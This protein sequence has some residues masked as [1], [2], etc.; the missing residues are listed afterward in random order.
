MTA[1]TM[2]Y[3]ISAEC[4]Q[5]PVSPVF[6]CHAHVCCLS[7]PSCPSCPPARLL[8]C[9]PAR[10]PDPPAVRGEK[11]P[12]SHPAPGSTA[13]AYSRLAEGL[14]AGAGRGSPPLP[15][16]ACCAL[17]RGASSRAVMLYVVVDR[18]GRTRNHDDSIEPTR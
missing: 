3:A 17:A 16:P 9:S 15:C 12:E 13:A 18:C 5:L 10:L 1:M 7:S 8:A 11:E 4:V 6:A 14:M 2:R